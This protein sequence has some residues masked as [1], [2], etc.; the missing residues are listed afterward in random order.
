M[1]DDLRMTT[2]GEATMNKRKKSK[3]EEESQRDLAGEGIKR[4]K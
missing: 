3:L 1:R 4:W 2:G